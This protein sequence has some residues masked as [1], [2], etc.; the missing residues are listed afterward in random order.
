MKA[1]TNPPK[2]RRRRVP[3]IVLTLLILGL[4]AFVGIRYYYPFGEGVKTGQLNFVVYKGI[5]FKTYEGRLIQSGFWS[6]QA[7]QIQSNE[8]TFSISDPR[9]ADQLMHAGGDMVELRYKEYFGALPWRGH[10]KYI[11]DSIISMRP[12]YEAVPAGSV[13]P[14]VAGGE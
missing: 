6:G 5:I 12:V 7:G 9:I 2:K 8:F 14:P 10:S 1:E 3:V 4:A 11:V 13:P